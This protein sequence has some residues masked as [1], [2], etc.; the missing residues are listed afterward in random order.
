MS[1]DKKFEAKV[2]VDQTQD[3]ALHPEQELRFE[4]EKV[5]K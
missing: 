4:A 3:Y 5:R 2:D 1:D